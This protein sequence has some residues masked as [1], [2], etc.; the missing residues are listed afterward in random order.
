MFK[1]DRA[2]SDRKVSNLKLAN[3]STT[4]PSQGELWGWGSNVYGTLGIGNATDRSSPVQVGSYSGWKQISQ[5]KSSSSTGAVKDDGTLWTWG[6]N[7]DGQLGLGNTT[8]YSSPK[9]VGSLTNWLSVKAS[10]SHTMALN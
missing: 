7:G 4:I 5:G 9:Q 3:V 2:L 8:S 10:D 1:L 6:R